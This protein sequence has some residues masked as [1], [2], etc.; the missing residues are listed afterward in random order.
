MKMGETKI[1]IGGLMRC[2][3]GTLDESDLDREVHSGDVVHCKWCKSS[4]ILEE[5]LWRWY[6]E[7]YPKDDGPL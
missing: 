5:G 4:M 3:I 6:R 7:I 1:S 2:C